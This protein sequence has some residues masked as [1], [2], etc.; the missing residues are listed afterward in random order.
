MGNPV[1]D[2]AKSAKALAINAAK[3]AAREPLE[4]LRQGMDQVVPLPVNEASRTQ[5]PSSLEKNVPS[6]GNGDVPKEEDIKK[7]DLENIRKL[8]GEISLIRGENL[9]KDLSQRI[10][11]GE[12]VSL[13]DITELTPEQKQVLMAQMEAVKQRRL[14]ESQQNNVPQSS[15]KPSRRFGGQKQAAQ[16]Q[17]TRVEKPVPPSG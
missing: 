2:S 8:E 11:Q 9:Y 13:T 6:A 16:Q 5:G 17:T 12:E 1:Q 4:I 3:K 14:M 10:S 7:T 15:S